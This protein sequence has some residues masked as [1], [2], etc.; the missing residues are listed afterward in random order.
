[1][2][3]FTATQKK[4]L[5]IKLIDENT[6]FVRMPNKQVFDSLNKL[7]DTITT[8]TVNDMESVNDIYSFMATILSN[9]K[10]GK[11]ITSEY[12]GTLLDIE[13]IITLFNSYMEFVNG[14]T[15]SPNS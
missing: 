13:D 7:R 10:Q 11:E 1:M 14:V 2:L 3:D 5:T 15:E 4:F 6:I 12:I 8:L 9:N